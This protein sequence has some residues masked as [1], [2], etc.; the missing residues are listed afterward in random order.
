MR[1]ISVSLATST[2]ILTR[3]T[4]S[5]R[6]RDSTVTSASL[7]AI[8]RS[9][10]AIHNDVV[11]KRLLR[12]RENIT[13]DEE[14]M[15]YKASSVDGVM[16]S[17]TLSLM[18]KFPEVVYPSNLSK[19]AEKALRKFDRHAI[20]YE[21]MKRYEDVKRAALEMKM[22]T[23]YAHERPPVLFD[24]ER[25][26]D[27]YHDHLREVFWTSDE[28]Q[29][30]LK[31]SEL[32][33]SLVFEMMIN[34]D[35]RPVV[36]VHSRRSFVTAD[37]EY[38]NAY[39]G[40]YNAAKRG[41]RLTLHETL[42]SCL[43]E[44]VELAS[45]LSIAKQNSHNAAHVRV[46]QLRLFAKWVKQNKT[47]DQVANM[48]EIP[49]QWEDTKASPFL[50][51]LIGYVAVFA[52]TRP[53]KLKDIISCLVKKFGYLYVAMFIEE[54]KKSNVGVFSELEITLFH[55]WTTD[56][57]NPMNFEQAVFFTESTVGE[58]DKGSILDRFSQRCF[59]G[60]PSHRMLPL[61]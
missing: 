28:V 61:N 4:N 42:K 18:K 32:H 5:S 44:G 16:H 48:M 52:H 35:V 41:K 38:L 31:D 46:E 53:E 27:S 12:A 21:Y 51:T 15:P 9:S 11:V 17:L 26:R 36:G 22:D 23:L 7:P 29:K 60:R 40:Q 2:A 59:S 37:L 57:I 50:D 54:G 39:I 34:D 43:G 55:H 6:T 25:Y 14:R 47:F 56:G 30:Q 33:P 24:M 8:L 13:A 45:F 1:L 19:A 49:G 20:Q 10:V 58:E 3:D